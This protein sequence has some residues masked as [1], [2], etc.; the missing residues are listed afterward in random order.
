MRRALKWAGIASPGPEVGRND[1]RPCARYCAAADK[2]HIIHDVK[3]KCRPDATWR[4]GCFAF[5][6]APGLPGAR[7]IVSDHVRDPNQ[8]CSFSNLRR[9]S[10]RERGAV[11][12]GR[13]RARRRRRLRSPAAH[14]LDGAGRRRRPWD[15]RHTAARVAHRRSRSDPDRDGVRAVKLSDA[16]GHTPGDHSDARERGFVSLIRSDISGFSPRTPHRPRPWRPRPWRGRPWRGRYGLIGLWR[17]PRSACSYGGRDG[18]ASRGGPDAF[19]GGGGCDADR[20]RRLERQR[21]ALER[22]KAGAD[23]VHIRAKLDVE[24]PGALI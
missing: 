1:P 16:C 11:W 21:G 5:P 22:P 7:P 20:G 6:G 8:C 23:P 3:P 17:R 12:R 10:R 19:D 24:R 13:N 14:R 2:S 9:P 15:R 4:T 18:D